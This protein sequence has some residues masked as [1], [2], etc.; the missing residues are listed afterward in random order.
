MQAAAN[1][2][3]KEDFKKEII[4]F[5]K[6]QSGLS[7]TEAKAK[8]K[9]TLVIDKWGNT[10]NDR[11]KVGNVTLFFTNNTNYCGGIK[12]GY[13]RG[14]YISNAGLTGGLIIK[15]SSKL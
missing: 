9:A 2:L 12:N 11:I 4:K 14:W 10:D 15:L 8:I 1:K 5:F 6:K 7:I 3:T 13:G